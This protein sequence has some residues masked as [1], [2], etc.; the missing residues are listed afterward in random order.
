MLTDWEKEISNPNSDEAMIPLENSHE[1]TL[2]PFED[3]LRAE[4]DEVMLDVEHKKTDVELM[5]TWT[6]HISESPRWATS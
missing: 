2:T 5:Y 6:R 4:I 1:I 3:L